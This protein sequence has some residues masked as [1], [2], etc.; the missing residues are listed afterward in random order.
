MVHWAFRLTGQMQMVH[1]AFRLT[2][3]NMFVCLFVCMFVCLFDLELGRVELG[4]RDAF[5]LKQAWLY[6]VLVH[7]ALQVCVCVCVC[8]LQVHRLI[9]AYLAFVC[10][11]VSLSQSFLTMHT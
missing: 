9:R 3:L 8:V 11:C 10:V 2:R 5:I 4:T 6:C 7:R 1:W